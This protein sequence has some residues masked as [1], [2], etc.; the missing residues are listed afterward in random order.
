VAGIDRRWR[1]EA[2]SGGG[3]G[4]QR[5]EDVEGDRAD[6]RRWRTEASV[7]VCLDWSRRQAPGIFLASLYMLA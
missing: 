3:T 5:G 7:G 6:D 2:L 4:R 1:T